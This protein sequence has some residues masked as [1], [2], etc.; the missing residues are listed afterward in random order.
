MP[1]TSNHGASKKEP[2]WNSWSVH[3]GDWSPG[4]PRRPRLSRPSS[5]V[6]QLVAMPD[7]Q[8]S[9]GARHDGVGG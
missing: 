8:P 1:R 2:L 9:L 4:R 3:V 6:G 5:P 7:P